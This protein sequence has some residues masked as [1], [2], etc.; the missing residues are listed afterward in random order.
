MSDG[1]PGGGDGFQGYLPHTQDNVQEIAYASRTITS[2]N[3]EAEFLPPAQGK[4]EW[5]TKL[6]ASRSS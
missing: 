2:G 4:E 1:V 6:D 5:G 3:S